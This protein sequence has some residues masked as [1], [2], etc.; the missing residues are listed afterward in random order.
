MIFDKKDKSCSSSPQKICKAQ[1]LNNKRI[2]NRR[3]TMYE[4]KQRLTRYL[5]RKTKAVFHRHKKYAKHNY[6]TIKE[7]RIGDARYMK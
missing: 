3:C 7:L 2:G 1:L 5:I 4:L 6:R